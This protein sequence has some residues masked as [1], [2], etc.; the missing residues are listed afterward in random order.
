MTP[1]QQKGI[2]ALR[3]VLQRM[4]SDDQGGYSLY[5]GNGK[6]AFVST[7]LPQTTP[8]ELNKLFAL[9]GVEPDMIQSLGSC[10]T[11]RY[12]IGGRSR[13]YARPCGSCKMPM[14]SNWEKRKKQN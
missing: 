3:D 10:K 11:C 6:W 7:G 12:S 8:E 13:G 9:V 5:Q 4:R 2:D 14:A 1:E